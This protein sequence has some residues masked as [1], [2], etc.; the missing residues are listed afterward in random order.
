MNDTRRPDATGPDYEYALSI[1]EVSDRYA[2]AGFPRTIRTLQRYCA[3]GHLDAQ[4]VATA[5]GDK[6]FVAPYSVNRHLAQIAEMTQFAP[7][8]PPA[9]RHDPSRQG[10]GGRAPWSPRFGQLFQRATGRDTPVSGQDALSHDNERQPPTPDRD[11][12]AT[13]PDDTPRPTATD[14]SEKTK[15]SPDQP[16]QVVPDPSLSPRYVERLEAENAF[17]RNQIDKKDQQI[18]ALIERDRETNVLV[19]GLQ[20]MLGPLLGLPGQNQRPDSETGRD[21]PRA[22]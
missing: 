9:T 15:P 22:D 13:E 3:S 8:T 21:T 4:K 2:A 12:V 17:L 20:R 11:S 6:Y 5:L 18:D 19:Q 7:Q 16:R 14:A 10:E 1:E